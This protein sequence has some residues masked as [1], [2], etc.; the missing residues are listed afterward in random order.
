M[1]DDREELVL[2]AIRALRRRACRLF[3]VLGLTRLRQRLDRPLVQLAHFRH[4][5]R[6]V[7]QAAD[8]DFGTVR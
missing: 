5:P 7:C 1:R 3:R 4:V 2:Q 6:L 8:E